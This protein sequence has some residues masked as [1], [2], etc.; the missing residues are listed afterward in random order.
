M[1]PKTLALISIVVGI[2]PV[3]VMLLG[4][5]L[6]KILGCHVDEASPHR[7][8]FFGRDIGG[9]L[10]GT[11]VFAWLALVTGPLAALGVT[12]SVIWWYFS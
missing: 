3:L 6:A 2:F 12:A 4:R 10:Y 8:L 1:T 7:C 11:F 9:F 5:L